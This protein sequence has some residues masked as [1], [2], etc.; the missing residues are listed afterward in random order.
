LQGLGLKN[1]NASAWVNGRKIAAEFG[2]LMFA[3]YGLSGPVILTLSR[4]VVEAVSAGDKVEISIDLKSALDEKKLDARLLRDLDAHG[5]KQVDNIF[6]LW[7]PSKLIP[8]FLKILEIDGNKLCHQLGSKERRKVLLLMKDFRF[9]VTGHPGYKEAIITAG[10]VPTG[11]INSRT[12]ESKLTKNLF[13]A[14]EVIDLDG[15]TGGF[16]LQIAFSTG[17]LAGQESCSGLTGRHTKNE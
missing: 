16:N 13:F 6:R 1:I 11:E 5:K 15:N 17:F 7:L 10:G 14:G 8:V 3:H 12:M 2:E 9:S 4:Q